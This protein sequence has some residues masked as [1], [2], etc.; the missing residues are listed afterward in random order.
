MP[1]VN[2]PAISPQENHR[3][4]DVHHANDEVRC[5][6][7]QLSPSISEVKGRTLEVGGA[8]KAVVQDAFANKS[9]LRVGG[10]R[11]SLS[12]IGRPKQHLLDMANHRA[13]GR[14][15]ARWFSADYI[16]ESTSAQRHPILVS[17]ALTI[18]VINRELAKLDLALQTT[19]ASDGQTFAGATATGTHGADLK[20]GAIHDTVRAIHLMVAP[21]KTLLIQPSDKPLL[22]D[23]GESLARWFGL[24]CSLISDDTL[25]HAA[26]VHLGS[27]GIV[28]NLLVEAV[29]L[30]YL[31][32]RTTP[33][34][35]DELCWRKV[36][37]SHR[38]QDADPRHHDDPDFLQFIVHPYRPLPRTEPR[39]W[40]SSMSKRRYSGEAGVQ[41]DAAAKSLK[42]DVADLLPTLVSLFENNIP[43][44]GN[45]ILRSV[46]STQMK[47]IYPQAYD[48]TQAL[49]GVMFGP[50]DFLGIDFDPVRGSSGE[51]V[52]N[53]MQAQAAVGVILETLKLQEKA[54]NQ[55]LGGLGV[56]F[57]KGSN[58]LLAPN[59]KDLNCFVELQGIY[60]KELPAIHTAVG[61]ALKAEGVPYGGHWGQWALNTPT[62]MERWWGQKAI[63]EWKKARREILS[64]TGRT[65]FASPIL[66]ASG[67]G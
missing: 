5:T 8:L 64:E 18:N 50:P 21:E 46:T 67:L 54:G 36:L 51:Y 34:L 25:F 41:T 13:I 33:H 43:L 53:A 23:A 24:E 29:P 27:M 49:P 58:A 31:Q 59:I 32:R 11:W 14:A 38:P 57:V 20:V 35:D 45:L 19:G 15:P 39:A 48:E 7:Y 12:N 6:R 22:A 9:P 40:L 16:D 63:D 42:S 65:V 26:L 61:A 4:R 10:G 37:S 52:F 28:L 1:T 30:Y 47:S 17:G 60:T 44:P 3:W 56:R 62:V 55:Y 66:A 2:H